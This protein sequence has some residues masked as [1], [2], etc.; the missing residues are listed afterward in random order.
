[1]SVLVAIAGVLRA[2]VSL[3]SVLLAPLLVGVL[4]LRRSRRAGWSVIA[5]T[6]AVAWALSTPFVGASLLRVLQTSPAIDP[7]LER[8]AL[9]ARADAIVVLAAEQRSRAPEYARPSI[10]A[11]TLERVRYAAEL[12]RRSGLPLC[13]SGGVPELG[14][15]AMADAMAGVLEEEFGVDVRWRESHS[16]NTRTNALN[17]AALL[18]PEGVR[19]VYV[20][21][22]AWHMPR[23]LLAFR[24]SGLEA[25][26]APT[27]FRA[28]ARTAL[29]A[30]WPTAR[31]LRESSLAWHELVGL[32]YYRL[33]H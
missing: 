2:F 33:R 4:L 13:T 12:A 21:T 31:G 22:H 29:S 15:P 9:R 5:A 6:G 20:V 17:S 30:F 24:E 19:R 25:V 3:P 32:V 8:A 26:P 11:F 14:E 23:S 10:G 1:V 18:L 28:P 16:A 7:A 27:A